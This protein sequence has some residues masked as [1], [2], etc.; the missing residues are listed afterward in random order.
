M[1]ARRPLIGW[2]L[3]AP[4]LIGVTAFLILPVIL[5]FVISLFNWD[6][7][8]T[9]QFVGLDNY[10]TLISGGTLIN[11]LLVTAIFTLISVPVSL[12]LGLALATQLVR[13]LPGSAI[14]RVIVV[15]PW[16]CAPLAL[17]VVWK[18]IFQPSVGA[19]NQILGVRIEWLTDPQLALPAV[20][21]VAI[22]QNVGYISLFFQ[23][24][25]GKIPTSIY[26]AARLDGAGSWQQMWHMTI[27][28]LRPTT[29]FLA[30]TQ[31]VA[32]F[33]VF[34]MVFALTGGG[35]QRRTEVIASLIYNEAF[36]ASRLGRASA[37]AVILFVILV[38]ITLIQQRYFS[39]RITYDM[40]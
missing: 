4:S 27:P 2:L 12:A 21:F 24:G 39:R 22:W 26:E 38:V 23:A 16:V 30:V 34:D 25:L 3:I 7:L 40:S 37:V 36:E 11:S 28:L 6:L 18:W 1:N 19:L 9:R 35:P 33:Q 29:F 13:A 31:V 8:G 20:A 32:S 10:T 17:G 15:I 5:A 14:V